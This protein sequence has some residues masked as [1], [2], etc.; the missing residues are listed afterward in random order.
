MA[1]VVGANA[2][3]SPPVVA[4]ANSTAVPLVV[5]RD[6]SADSASLSRRRQNV[7]NAHFRNSVSTWDEIYQ[8][9]SELGFMVQGRHTLVLDWVRELAL[10]LDEKILDIGCGAG[11]TSVALA[12]RGHS[13]V[14]ADSVLNMLRRTLEHAVEAHADQRTRAVAGDIQHL[15]FE[16]GSFG[17]V[18]ALGVLPYI[19]SPQKA[20][21]EMA[22]VLRPGGY[23]IFSAHNFWAL[24]DLFDPATHI[25]PRKSRPLAPIRRVIKKLLRQPDRAES[26]AWPRVYSTRLVNNWV[27][28]ADL[29]KIKDVTIGFGPFT[30]FGH[31]LLPRS[32]GVKLYRRLQNLADRSVLGFRS[33]G[34]ERVILA[35]KATAAM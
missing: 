31:E 34:T 1:E 27:S 3:L 19:Y 6:P 16:G 11:L 24:H 15:C 8:H 20:I 35:R 30:C 17:L 32:V 10:S 7:I 28:V 2:S 14:A 5:A 29:I 25:D 12:Q 21:A 18:L 13:V 9:T 4:V 22:R 23:V 26:T 33:I